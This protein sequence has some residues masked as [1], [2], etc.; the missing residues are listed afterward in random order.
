MAIKMIA[1]D[2]DGT[3]LNSAGKITEKTEKAIR[4]AAEKGV[5]VV[6]STGRAYT[7][8]PEDVKRIEVIKYA[9]TSNGSHIVAMRTGKALYSE[10]LSPE[11]ALR[12]ADLA[13]E[14]DTHL[15]IFID[16]QAYIDE[17][18][19]N[20]I[21]KYGCEYRNAEYVLWSRKPVRDINGMLRDNR[22]KIE[23]INFCFRDLDTLEASRPAIESIPDSIITSSI[24]N[25]LEVGGK[26]ATKINAV[27]DLMRRLG[28]MESELMCCGDAPNDIS[29]L[30]AAGI[31]VAMGNAW[32]G[33]KDYADYVTASND[34]DGVA[35]A[36]EKFVLNA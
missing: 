14:L 18:Y 12:A 26:K 9:I 19:Y 31:G 2:L 24:R 7:S 1:I 25:N 29:M 34:E 35:E 15:E 17:E 8:L 32:G 21:A 22:D 13:E 11:A 6:I 36:I 33:T 20:H 10:Y 28:V 23:N 16:G 4:A 30:R 3:A 5:H 27:I